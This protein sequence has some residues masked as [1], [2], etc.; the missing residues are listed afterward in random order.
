[1]QA[2]T[3]SSLAYRGIDPSE[4]MERDERKR[5]LRIARAISRLPEEQWNEKVKLEPIDKQEEIWCFLRAIRTIR[6]L[7]R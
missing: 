6:T 7:P 2:K 3:K 5:H 1:M 4:L